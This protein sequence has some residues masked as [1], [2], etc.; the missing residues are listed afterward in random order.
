MRDVYKF[1]RKMGPKYLN[2]HRFDKFIGYPNEKIIDVYLK[3]RIKC[4]IF[5]VN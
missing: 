3:E 2:F 1:N 5:N 4:V